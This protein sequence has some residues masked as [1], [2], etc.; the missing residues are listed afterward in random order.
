MFWEQFQTIHQSSFDFI[1]RSSAVLTDPSF[2][3]PFSSF[4]FMFSHCFETFI[5]DIFEA[6]LVLEIIYPSFPIFSSYLLLLSETLQL[7]ITFKPM[8]Y[9]WSTNQW[10]KVLSLKIKLT[11]FE[12]VLTFTGLTL[13]EQPGLS[14]FRALEFDLTSLSLSLKQLGR[15]SDESS[16]GEVHQGISNLTQYW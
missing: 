6:A 11:C 1:I 16:F 3:I 2:Y 9:V 14:T 4:L 10:R 5:A 13:S 7:C 15:R 12:T 8:T